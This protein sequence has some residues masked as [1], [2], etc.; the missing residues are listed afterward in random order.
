MIFLGKEL[1]M[2]HDY[3]HTY[4]SKTMAFLLALVGFLGVAGLHRFYVGK[5]WTG[6][7]WLLTV[8]LF[9]LGTIVDLLLIGTNNFKDKKGYP[10]AT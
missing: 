3:Y 5:L 9:G 2:K 6:L 10:L 1:T 4:S 8:G 7:L